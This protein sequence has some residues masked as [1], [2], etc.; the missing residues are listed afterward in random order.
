MNT[1][2]TSHKQQTKKIILTTVAVGAAGIL[3][4]FGW[5]YYKKKKGSSSGSTDNNASNLDD[6]LKAG[7]DNASAS[8]NFDDPASI[9]PG[10]KPLPKKNSSSPTPKK[11]TIDPSVFPL[12]RGSKNEQVKQ[13]QEALISK[14]GKSILPK[15]GADSSFGSEMAAA[16]KKLGLPASIDQSTFNVLTESSSESS[17]GSSLGTELFNAVFNRDFNKV[18]SLLKKMKTKDDYVSANEV[19]KTYRLGAVR[20]TIVNALLNIFNSADQKQKIKFELLRIGLQYD[21]NQW[22]L[23]GMGGLAIIT[24]IPTSVWMNARQCMRVPARM[25]LGN[26]IS[27]RLGYTLFENRGKYFL[28]PTRAVQY[29]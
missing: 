17:S 26:E 21:G 28:V 10:S 3:G 27:K 20:Q 15:Y 4:Y 23:S 13:L 7:A 22:S 16:L 1:H 11:A 2:N 6:L 14:Y 5:Q 12:K 18:M 9:A 19:F 25:V 29:L 8:I 24:I